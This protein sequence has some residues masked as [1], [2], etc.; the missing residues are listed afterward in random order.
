MLWLLPCAPPP[1]PPP[2]VVV[3][4]VWTVSCEDD[5]E[6]GGVGRRASCVWN[7]V[8]LIDA[9]AVCAALVVVVVVVVVAVVDGVL[10]PAMFPPWRC[11]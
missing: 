6:A 1:P 5:G 7:S 4:W 8:L 2:A 10:L 3:A 9:A 11:C